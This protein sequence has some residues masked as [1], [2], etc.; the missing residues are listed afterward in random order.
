FQ[1][2]RRFDSLGPLKEADHVQ[3]YTAL[4]WHVSLKRKLRV[5]VLINRKNPAKPRYIVLASTA[6]DLAGHTLVE[7]YGARFQIEICQSQPAKMPLDT[8]VSLGRPKLKNIT[9]REPVYAL[10]PEK[11]TGFR[12]HLQVQRLKLT[13]WRRTVQ[14]MAAV[15]VLVWAGAVTLRSFRAT[16]PLE[17]PQG[18]MPTAAAPLPVPDKPSIV[19]LP[20]VNLSEDPKQEYFS[21]GLTEVLTSDLAKIPS[22]FVIARNSAFT[23]KGKAVK[24]QEVGHEMG[25]RYVLEGSVLKAEGQVRIT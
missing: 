17:Q 23:Y 16:P 11:P 25:V 7:L 3:L 22:L 5:V 15:L 2:L 8:V 20:F 19:V 9:Q 13:H 21:D 4:V 24:V 12:Q 6:L 1:D 10:L 18:A 14:V